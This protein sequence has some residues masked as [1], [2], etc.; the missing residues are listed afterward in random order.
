MSRRPSKY[1]KYFGYILFSILLVIVLLYYRFPSDALKNYVQ[2]AADDMDANYRVSIGN[3][4]PALPFGVRLFDTVVVPKNDSE[5]NV[6]TADTL[7]IRPEIVSFIRGRLKYDF[8]CL[9]YN[10][11]LKGFV[12]FKQR[13]MDGP[14]T[15]MIELKGIHM[16]DHEYL[17]TLIGRNVKGILNG[18]VNY[19]GQQDILINGNGEANLTVSDG[20]VQLLKP[21]FGLESVDFDDLRIRMVLDKRKITLTNAQLEGRNLKGTLSGTVSLKRDLRRSSLALKGSIELSAGLFRGNKGDSD[22]L[23]LLSR[24][25]GR[26]KISF[27]IRGTPVNPRIRFT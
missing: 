27:V 7:L 5:T 2:A 23:K 25:F 21:I 1:K 26:G 18:T 8:D 22:A 6:F 20:W 12:R 13:G 16:A 24:G 4:R 11:D 3:A 14:F 9:A 15:T 19:S 10:G 17:S